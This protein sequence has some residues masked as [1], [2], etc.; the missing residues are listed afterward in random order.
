MSQRCLLGPLVGVAR[1]RS[2]Y[3]HQTEKQGSHLNNHAIKSPR[4]GHPNM[5][6][7]QIAGLAGSLLQS[8][9]ASVE[10]VWHCIEAS[11]R[12]APAGLGVRANNRTGHVKVLTLLLGRDPACSGEDVSVPVLL[13]LWDFES[14]A[15]SV[16][17]TRYCLPC[18]TRPQL[19]L[20]GV[21]LESF[22]FSDGPSKLPCCAVCCAVLCWIAGEGR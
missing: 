3:L 16:G 15:A 20:G 7:L 17:S 6:H 2:G 11:E 14:M 19:S 5:T 9:T 12:G 22:Y 18:G 10:G 1:S 4:I 8:G 21:H 13:V